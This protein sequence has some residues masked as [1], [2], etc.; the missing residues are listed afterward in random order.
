MK[1]IFTLL[2]AVTASLTL[3]AQITLTTY[4]ITPPTSGCNGVWAL[5]PASAGCFGMGSSYTFNPPG[6]ALFSPTI[7][8]DTI[9]YPVCSIPC[10]LMVTNSMSGIY[11]ICDMSW[12]DAGSITAP[13]MQTIFTSWPNPAN[14]NVLHLKST[15]PL[16]TDVTLIDATGRSVLQH[17][18]EQL[19]D[20]ETLDISC[21]TAGVYFLKFETPGGRPVYQRI[22]RL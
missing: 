8:G 13:A 10:S 2:F 22:V 5:G 15:I 11:C 14:S 21:I 7:S 20:L 6:C 17:H 19:A 3:R 1:F 9:F 12:L 18:Y 16:Q 4:Y